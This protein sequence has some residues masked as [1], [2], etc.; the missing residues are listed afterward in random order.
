MQQGRYVGS[1]VRARLESHDALPFHYHDKDNLATIGRG[2][3]VA[4]IK[5]LKLS[6][7]L[8]WLTWLFV[9]LWYLVG[10]ENRVLVFTRWRFGFVTHGRGTQLITGPPPGAIVD[11]V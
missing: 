11:D 4:D 1:V 8:A 3:V 10:F 7:F 9:H 5:P 6:G 2:S